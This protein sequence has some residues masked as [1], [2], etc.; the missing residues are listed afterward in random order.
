MRRRVA[1]FRARFVGPPEPPRVSKTPEE[2][3]AQER[4]RAAASYIRRRDAGTLRAP[5][6]PTEQDRAKKCE[7]RRLARQAFRAA[8]V[9]PIRPTGRPPKLPDGNVPRKAVPKVSAKR[10]K[11]APT[12]P[13][14][15]APIDPAVMEA[16]MAR[17]SEAQRQHAE[18][19]PRN[20]FRRRVDAEQARMAALG[21]PGPPATP[22]DPATAALVAA[23]RT[24]V[25]RVP[26]IR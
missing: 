1:D 26:F 12:S 25:R 24:P 4:A 16:A 19:Q 14:P 15:R 18:A 17:W 8:F 6:P 11:P 2:R 3:A 21:L 7:R 13:A 23:M 22:T 10:A 5:R 9:G 20:A